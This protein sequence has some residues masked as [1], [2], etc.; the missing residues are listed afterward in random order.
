MRPSILRLRFIHPAHAGLVLLY[1]AGI[2]WLSA[3]SDLKSPRVSFPGADKAAH[4]AL[5]AGL[6][7]LVSEGLRRAPRP[8][9]PGTQ[10]WAPIVFAVLYG[11]TDEIHQVFTPRRSCDPLD[12]LADAAGAV[13]AQ[14]VLFACRGRAG[15]S[16]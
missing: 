3:Q 13:A 12:L 10:L 15:N 11:V 4:A 2:F 14:A 16:G 1:C 9:A 5:Y 7:G 6:A 8:P